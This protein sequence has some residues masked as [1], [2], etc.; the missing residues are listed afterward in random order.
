[1]GAWA[2]LATQPA[3]WKAALVASRALNHLPS[4]LIPIPALKAWESK[5]E[6]PPW[7][8]GAFRSWLKMRR[9]QAAKAQS[10]PK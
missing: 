6:L 3:A 4:V 8:G 2:L 9:Q 10:R 7:R 1:M 5:R